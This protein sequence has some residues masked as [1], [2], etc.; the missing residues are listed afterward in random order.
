MKIIFEMTAF[1]NAEINKIRGA[2][3]YRVGQQLKDKGINQ[4]GLF[5]DWVKG[6]VILSGLGRI[7]SVSLGAIGN[8][9][10]PT[11]TVLRRGRG[12][13]LSKR[14]RDSLLALYKE[15]K[16]TGVEI[17]KRFG[18]S[19]SLVTVLAKSAGLPLRRRGRR[20]RVEPSL[21]AQR[22]LRE[23]WQCTYAQ[24]GARF[25]LSKQRIAHLVKRWRSWATVQFG[26]RKVKGEE[27]D[28]KQTQPRAND[29]VG[30]TFWNDVGQL[31]RIL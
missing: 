17:A 20:P 25:D 15:G 3:E 27:I 26:R 16:E 13:P 30:D 4:K 8:A 14:E 29:S 5:P 9:N 28:R 11:V 1:W 21:A 12:A 10:V 22:I 7:H 19:P 31:T 2:V 23:A 18:V 6:K 24:A